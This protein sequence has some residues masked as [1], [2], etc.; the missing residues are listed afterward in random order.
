MEQEDY[1]CHHGVKGMK[2]GRRKQRT[3]SGGV[4]KSSTKK[5]SLK[6]KINKTLKKVDKDKVKLI[7]ATAAITLGSVAAAALVGQYGPVVVKSIRLAGHKA[8]YDYYNQLAGK[9]IEMRRDGWIPLHGDKF[10][11]KGWVKSYSSITSIK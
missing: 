3:K 5:V 4:K 7:A 9:A 8:T 2:W 1:L 11:R 6:S 10:G